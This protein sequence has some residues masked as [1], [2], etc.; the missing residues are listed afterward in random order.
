MLASAD[1]N[2]RFRLVCNRLARAALSA[3]RPSG[4]STSAAMTIPTTAFGTSSQAIPI[5]SVG[6]RDLA[7]PTTATR[8]AS[9]RSGADDSRPVRGRRRVRFLVVAFER[10]EVVAVPHGLDEDERAVEHQR[11]DSGEDK[12]RRAEHRTGRGRDDVRQNQR[13]G[14]ER[15]QHGQCGA[16]SVDLKS[17]FVMARAAP[18]QAQAD[19]A[20]A[21]DHDGGEDRVAC[22]P[23]LFRR[24]CNHDRDD[25]RHLDNRDGDGQDKRAEWLAGAVCD[26]LGV[27]H[28]REHGGD[29]DRSCSR[30][31]EAA[32]AGKGRRSTGSPR[33]IRA[34]PMP[35]KVS[36]LLPCRWFPLDL[37]TRLT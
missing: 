16:R 11:D 29:Q 1:P 35:T 32:G 26:H 12:L 19:D 33:P 34:M 36:V 5:S 24:S 10:E 28:G 18:E 7:R 37:P 14:G 21:H 25:Q 20:V 17:L 2:A 22:Q 8:A 3:A 31:N 4:S 9:S 27:V 15:G 30:G 23:C 13:E 6:V